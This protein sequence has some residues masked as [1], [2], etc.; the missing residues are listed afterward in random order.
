MW[1]LFWEGFAE[2]ERVRDRYK[3]PRGTGLGNR[4]AST[5]P[6]YAQTEGGGECGRQ[7]WFCGRCRVEVH[8]AASPGKAIPKPG[9]E[10]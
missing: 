6:L 5:S 9:G 7:W 4:E 8:L 2:S 1:Q 3:S 10:E